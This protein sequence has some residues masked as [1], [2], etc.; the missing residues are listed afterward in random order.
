MYVCM[1]AS[2]YVCMYVSV[3]MYV[4]VCMYVYMHLCMHTSGVLEHKWHGERAI[5]YTIVIQTT[6]IKLSC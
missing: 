5:N 6:K 2:M 4:C 3:C 1:H